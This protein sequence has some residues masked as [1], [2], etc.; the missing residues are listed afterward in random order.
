LFRL[1]PFG[2]IR[3]IG[4]CLSALIRRHVGE[5]ISA[6]VRRHIVEIV[7]YPNVKILV[8]LR[9]P[10]EL[11]VRFV[12]SVVEGSSYI[13]CSIMRSASTGS[14]NSLTQTY[15]V[16]ILTYHEYRG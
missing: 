2:N 8:Y 13:I 7:S 11:I 12:N 5:T 3:L 10:V 15:D 1:A 9:R 4:E 14:K 6:L 16:E